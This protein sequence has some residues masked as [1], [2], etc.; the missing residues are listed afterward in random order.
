MAERL[1][2]SIDE[3]IREPMTWEETWQGED[4]G[5]IRSWERGREMQ[6]QRPELAEAAQRGEL[7]ILPWRGGIEGEL[8]IKSKYGAMQYL[9]MWQGLRDED[10]DVPTDADE[11]LK[12][13]RTGIL[14]TF[15]SDTSKFGSG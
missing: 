7:P 5:L 3:P 13:A 1:H 9:A 8:K 6:A 15:T 2:R 14:V 10:L 11:Q 4:R 12:C